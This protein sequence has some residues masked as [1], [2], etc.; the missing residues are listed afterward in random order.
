MVEIHFEKSFVELN[1]QSNTMILKS[2]F[3]VPNV[4]SLLKRKSE[5]HQPLHC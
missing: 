2:G 3:G 4:S 5:L 1:F